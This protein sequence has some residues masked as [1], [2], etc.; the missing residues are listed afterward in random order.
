M[1]ALYRQAERTGPVSSATPTWWCAVRRRGVRRHRRVDDRV[2]AHRPPIPRPAAM[3]DPYTLTPTARRTRARRPAG[4]PVAPRPRDRPRTR[5]LLGRGV[6]DGR[7]QHPHRP[8][9]QRVA[10]LRLRQAVRVRRADER[11][12]LDRRA[13]GRGDGDRRERRDDRRSAAATSTGCRSRL[14]ERIAPEAGHRPERTRP[15]TGAL[16]VETYTTTTTGARYRATMSQQGDPGLQGD[17]G[18]AR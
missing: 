3:N 16:H 2:H 18:A 11:G 5:R 17:L 1:F 10:R 12:P 9:Q 14:L 6:R 7:A 4:H 13:G 8:A 15:R